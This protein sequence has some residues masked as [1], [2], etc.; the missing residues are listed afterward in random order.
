LTRIGTGIVTAAVILSAL[1]GCKS[2]AKEM[3]TYPYF[4]KMMD[5]RWDFARN[6][7]G[8]AEPDVSFCPVLLKDLDGIVEAVEATYHRSNKQQLIDKVKDI[9]RSFRADLDPQVDM[10]YGHVTLKP[11]ATAEDVSKSVETAY[12]K[13]LEFRKMVKLE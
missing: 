8:S 6:S 7:L 2:K 9:A 10:R 5:S 4:I 11:G 3:S 13:Y 1:A 12:Q